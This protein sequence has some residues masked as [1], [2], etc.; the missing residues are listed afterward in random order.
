[1]A[2]AQLSADLVKIDRFVAVVPIFFVPV[3]VTY[4]EDVAHVLMCDFDCN[5][6]IIPN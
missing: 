6:K 1:M 4:L 5:Y 3:L 2:D